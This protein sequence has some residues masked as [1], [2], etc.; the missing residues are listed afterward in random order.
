MMIACCKRFGYYLRKVLADTIYCNRLKRAELKA[1]LQGTSESWII[2]FILVL[3]FVKLPG[4]ALLSHYLNMV[5][6]FSADLLSNKVENYEY[7]FLF[8]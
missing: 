7:F 3:N 6:R 1:R 4:V 2:T 8:L 5:K